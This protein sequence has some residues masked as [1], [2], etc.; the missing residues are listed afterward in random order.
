MLCPH[1]HS[2]NRRKFRTEMMIH[3]GRLEGALPDLLTFPR[4]WMCFECGCSTFTL[5]QN[6]LLELR[7]A[8]MNNG[9]LLQAV[10]QSQSDGDQAL[11]RR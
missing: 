11:Q 5:P 4:A 2:S 9:V 1:C 3:H 10:A 8:C 6:E 7:E